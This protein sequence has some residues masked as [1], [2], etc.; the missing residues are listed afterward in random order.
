MISERRLASVPILPQAGIGQDKSR[1]RHGQLAGV[2][3]GREKALGLCLGG[4][5]HTGERE[6]KQ[7]VGSGAQSNPRPCVWPSIAP[8][9]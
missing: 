8:P 1:Q 5:A 2:T 4:G 6:R 3:R 9:V 7:Q